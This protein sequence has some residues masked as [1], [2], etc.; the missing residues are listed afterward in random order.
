[1][2]ALAETVPAYTDCISIITDR[3]KAGHD[4]TVKLAARLRGRGLYVESVQP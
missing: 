1:M 3:N 2:P 4:N